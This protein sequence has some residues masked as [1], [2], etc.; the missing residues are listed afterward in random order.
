MNRSQSAAMKHSSKRP[1]R[2]ERAQ[3]ILL[4]ALTLP[5]LIGAMAMSADVGVLYFNWQCLQSAADAGAVAGAAYLPSNSALAISIANR[6]ASKNG[7]LPGEIT[8]TTVSSDARSLNIQLKRTVPYSFALLLGLVTGTVSAQA[9]AQ[10]QTI[11]KAIGVTPM[12][13]DYRTT[14]SSGQVITLMQGQV[15][16]GNWGPLALGASSASNLL[17]NI[18]YGYQGSIATADLVTTQTGLA[19]GPIRSAF[20]FLINAG[21]NIDPGGTFASHTPTDPRVLIV[22]MVDFSSING[23]SQVPV[24]GFAA[25]WLVSVDNS[26]TIQTYFINQVAPGSTPDTTGTSTNYGA[27]EAVLIQ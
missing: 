15:G 22:P 3:I 4:L 9:T 23:N 18:E 26:N 2:S 6:F 11:G 19:T 16:P 12:G 8:S 10:I 14:Y 7:I 21:Q 25:L 1:P 13:I 24:K 17:Q 5:V 27:F 20:D